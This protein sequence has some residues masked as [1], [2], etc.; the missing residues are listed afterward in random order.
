M[1]EALGKSKQES[2]NGDGLPFNKH[3]LSDYYV[4]VAGWL[5]VNKPGSVR[6]SL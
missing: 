3:L 5:K 2:Y 1:K 4:P 6:G